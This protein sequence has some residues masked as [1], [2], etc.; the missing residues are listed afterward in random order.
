[1]NQA[2]VS[3]WCVCVCVCVCVCLSCQ[4]QNVV[5][6]FFY[7]LFSCL[8]KTAARPCVFLAGV[9]FLQCSHLPPR[10]QTQGLHLDLVLALLG[11][12]YWWRHWWGHGYWWGHRPA[13]K[14]WAG[15]AVNT[16]VV[17][18]LA[19]IHIHNF[20]DHYDWCLLWHSRWK[21]ECMSKHFSAFLFILV[22][23]WE[24]LKIQNDVN[25]PQNWTPLIYVS[26]TITCL[27][28]KSSLT[29]WAHSWQYFL[30]WQWI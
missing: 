15:W 19:A 20:T 12:P 5:S 17:A 26:D 30:R 22:F 10:P 24:Q 6:I 4:K 18:L 16:L 14:N 9:S 21:D 1:M 8:W 23:C 3:L 28:M 2:F 25:S 13:A 7:M 27:F 11:P 29:F